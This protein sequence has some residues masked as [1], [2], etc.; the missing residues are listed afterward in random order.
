MAEHFFLQVD[1]ID[2]ESLDDKHLNWI[3]IHAWSWGASQSGTTHEGPGAGGGKVNVSDLTFTKFVDKATPGLL[4]ACFNGKHIPKA[5]FHVLKAGGDS[6][7]LYL[8]YILTDIIVSSYNS[9][10]AAGGLDRIEETVTFNFRE[11]KIEYTQQLANGGLGATTP[12]GWDIA[13][14]KAV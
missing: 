9:G 14:N 2:G 7:V 1:G 11:V 3:D 12:V 5:E 13:A 4:K 10:G 8:K 6:P